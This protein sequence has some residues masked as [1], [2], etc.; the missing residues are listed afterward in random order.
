MADTLSSDAY[1]TM[2]SIIATDVINVIVIISDTLTTDVNSFY[3]LA[4]PKISGQ[5][6]D[7]NNNIVES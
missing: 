6:C 5:S 1:C 2:H 3:R 4:H 7:I